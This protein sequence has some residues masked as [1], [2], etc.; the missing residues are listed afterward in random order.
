MQCASLFRFFLNK[1]LL[2]V[3]GFLSY[4]RPA[5]LTAFGNYDD[6]QWMQIIFILYDL[7]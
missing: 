2:A 1:E 7:H 4:F 5:Y 3:L 6:S